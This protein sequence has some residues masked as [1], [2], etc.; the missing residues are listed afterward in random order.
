MKQLVEK[1]NEKDAKAA[2]LNEI[3]REAGPDLDLDKV[4]SLQGD[5]KS[6]LTQLQTMNE[7]LNALAAEVEQMAAI[8]QAAKA[9]RA[10]IEEIVERL[11]LPGSKNGEQKDSKGEKQ[12]KR[13]GDLV[14][15]SD[16]WKGYKGGS[17]GPM[18]TL[19]IEFKALMDTATGWTVEN[20]RRPNVL[21]SAQEMPMVADLIPQTTTTGNAIKY[22]EETTFTNA[23]AET[24]EGVAKPEATLALTE[25]TSTVRKIAVWIPATDELFEDVARA[26]DYVEN[27]LRFMLLQRLDQQI[28]TGDGTAPNLRGIHN[29]V[30]IGVQ[31]KGADPTPDAVYKAMTKVRVTGKAIPSGVVFHPNDWQEVR[32]LRTADGLYIWGSPSEAGPERIWGLPVIQSAFE[33]EGEALTGDFRNHSEL[34]FRSGVDVQVSSEHSTYFTEN[35]LAIR[36]EFRVALI[37]DR[38]AA[39][40][41]ITGI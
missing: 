18:A 27:R 31:A 22:M 10:G 1:R 3:W 30:G 33:T 21:L 9:A 28:L 16:A 34:A 38:P 7:E 20:V 23:A 41:E 19:D 14:V 15:E 11:P 39:F 40:T 35:K 2:R 36:A 4:T 12:R 17:S 29:V 32:L 6:K 5:S 8:E 37:V 25:R 13:F 24:A 26:R